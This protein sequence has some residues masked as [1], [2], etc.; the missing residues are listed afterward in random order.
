MCIRDRPWP[1]DGTPEELADGLG[2]MG[3]THIPDL[4][5]CCKK[6]IYAIID[7]CGRSR[8]EVGL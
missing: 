6:L 5:P 3:V 4:V 8:K 7:T 1:Y 2:G